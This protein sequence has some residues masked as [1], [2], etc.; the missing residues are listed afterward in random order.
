[1]ISVLK[2]ALGKVG[3]RVVVVFGIVCAVSNVSH[4]AQ[5]D[6][7]NGAA[8]QFAKEL[9][10]IPKDELEMILVAATDAVGDSLMLNGTGNE[11]RARQKYWKHGIF[12]DD[13]LEINIPKLIDLCAAKWLYERRRGL[14]R[15]GCMRPTG[16]AE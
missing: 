6:G 9:S 4:A 1:P 3:G 14:D 5:T 13:D 16:S 7:L 10:P 15:T 12:L 11:Y 2:L 8:T